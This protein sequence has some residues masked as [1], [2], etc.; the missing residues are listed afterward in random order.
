MSG[1]LLSTQTLMAV[2][3]SYA[4]SLESNAE[5]GQPCPS[6]TIFDKALKCILVSHHHLA[7]KGHRKYVVLLVF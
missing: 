2:H 6:C 7:P 3:L 5:E 4:F 1:E